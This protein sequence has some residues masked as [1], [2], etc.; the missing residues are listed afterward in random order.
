MSETAS[1]E[2][3]PARSGRGKI[4]LS[5]AVLLAGLG[6]FTASYLGIVS[7]SEFLAEDRMDEA[8][9]PV[10]GFVDV[11]RIAVPMVGRDRQLVLSIKLEVVPDK[12]AEIQLLM[13]RVADSF[14]SFL[15]DVDPAAIDR[16]GVLEIIRGELRARADMIL[17]A[18]VVDNVLITEFAIQ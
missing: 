7:P 15:S 1:A 10:M 16:R 8:V 11:P 13:P 9:M 12:V 4:M 18:D 2:E 3:L 14:N 17:G 6:A 5:G